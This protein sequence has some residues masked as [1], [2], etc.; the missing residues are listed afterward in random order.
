ML[1]F[2]ELS[3]V[4]FLLMLG[5]TEFDIKFESVE[6]DEIEKRMFRQKRKKQSSFFLKLL[7]LKLKRNGVR[8]A[9]I[10]KYI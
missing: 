7:N 1:T 8:C 3:I 10:R 4:L 2:P 5:M 9:L 6:W